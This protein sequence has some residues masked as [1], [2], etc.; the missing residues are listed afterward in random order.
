MDGE[1]S[2]AIDAPFR[3]YLFVERR[4]KN[5]HCPVRGYPFAKGC[6]WTGQWYLL[7]LILQTGRPWTGHQLPENFPGNTG[8]LSPKFFKAISWIIF[9]AL[10]SCLS[11]PDFV[12]KRKRR[13]L[14]SIWPPFPDLMF[15]RSESWNTKFCVNWPICCFQIPFRALAHFRYIC[16]TAILR[17]KLQPFQIPR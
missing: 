12:Q 8:T 15:H 9:L 7:F 2:P 6:P 1:N 16:G 5:E 3:G 14:L 17:K 4:N 13:P 10:D 11:V